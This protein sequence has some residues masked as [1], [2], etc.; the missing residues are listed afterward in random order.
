M[1]S[2]STT[3]RRALVTEA[4]RRIDELTERLA[5]A[6]QGDR[7]PIAVVGIG[8]RL[9]GGV[10]DPEE[11]WDLLDNGI[12]GV[13]RVPGDRWDADELYSPDHTVPGTICNREG[14]FLTDWDPAAFDAEFFGISPREAAGMDPQHR[15]L[16]EV[17]WQAL[18]HAGI[19]PTSLRGSRTGV[20][21]GLTTTDYST[22]LAGALE[23]DEID[24]YV[25]F[26]SAHNFA[27][28]RLSYFLGLNGPAVVL[29][30]ACSSSLSALHLACQGLRSRESD[31]AL[32]AGVNLVLSPENSIACSRWGMLAPD[33]RCKPF[34]ASADGYVR[35]EGCGVVVLK[36]LSDAVA[37]GD[38]VLAV[39][40]G[41]AVNQ[42]G[43]SSGQTVPN[44]PAQQALLR[45]ALEISDLAP[46]TIDFIES[47]GTGTALGD[48]IELDTLARVFGERAGAAP[49]VIGAVK[50]NLGHLESAAGMAGFI[51]T[52]LAL[53]RG[54]I[55]GN[56]HFDA[57]TP[58]AGEG[59]EK[60]VFPTG[61]IDWPALDRP[62]RA[63]VSSFGVSGTNA[64]V[65][66]EQAPPIDTAQDADHLSPDTAAAVARLT[67]SGKSIERIKA[68]A[69][70]LAHWLDGAG[71]S[72]PLADV[73]HELQF[74]RPRFPRIATVIA[75]DHE[76]AV[77][78]LH[79]LAEGRPAPG[80]VAPQRGGRR[81]GTVFVFSGQ[82]AQWAGMGRRLMA[83]DPAFAA[84][85]RELDADFRDVVGFSLEQA[86]SDASPLSGIDR[87]QPVL[88]GVQLALVELWKSRGVEPDA[89]IGHSMG[90]VAAAV[91]AGALSVRDGLTVIATRSA[92][93]KRDLAGR[94]AMALLELDADAAAEVAARHEGVSVA[95]VASPR[96]TV[97][98]GDPDRIDAAI[99]EVSARDLLARRIDVDVASHHATVDPIL[100]ELRASLADI[101]PAVPQIPFHSTV[102][103]GQ[104]GPRVDADYWADN[105]RRPVLFA[106]A[107]S[108]AAKVCGTFI[109]I[110]PHPLLTSAIEDVVDES[111]CVV[112]TLLRDAA[113]AVQFEANLTAVRGPGYPVEPQRPRPPVDLPATQWMRQRHWIVP[114]ASVIDAPA[115][116]AD[117]GPHGWFLELAFPERALAAAEPEPRRWLVVTDED[118]DEL[119]ALLGD[120]AL[121]VRAAALVDDTGAV[122]SALHGVDRVVYAPAMPRDGVDPSSARR[123]VRDVATLIRLLREHGNGARLTVLTRNAEA[124]SEGEVANPAHAALWGAG[125]T[126]ALEHP[127]LWG[128]LID[129]DAALPP[130]LVAAALTAE[131]GAADDEDQV[132]YRTGVRRVPRL[133]R[134]T[135]PIAR[136]DVGGDETHLVIGAT[137]NIGGDV[138]RQL[139]RMGARTV[140]A[141]S[142]RGGLP[143]GLEDELA[144]NGT[145]IVPVAIDAA[146][147]SAMTELFARFG[148]DLPPLGGVYV[149]S[150]AG[151]A[152]L[153]SELSADDI[154]AM[155]RA[156][157]DVLAIV[158]ELSLHTPLRDL[159]VFSSITGLTGSRWLGHYTAANAYADAV[160]AVRRHLGLPVRVVD[161]GLFESWAQAQP[162]TASAGLTPMPND[163]AV[164]CLPYVLGP[165][166]PTRSVIAGADWPL[167]AESFR[168]RAPMKILD[169]LLGARY[170]AAVDLPAP[171][172]GSVQGR[173]D[174]DGGWL[175]GLS[176]GRRP[177]PTPHRVRGVEVV[178]VSVIAATLASVAAGAELRDLRFEYPIVL[179]R[180]RAVHV[181]RSD[182]GI[183]ITSSA[184]PNAAAERWIRHASAGFG[185]ARAGTED[186]RDDAGTRAA[187]FETPEYDA[188][189]VAD[190]VR[191][192]GV[193]GR[194]FPW[195]VTGYVSG[196]GSI[197]AEVTLDADASVASAT[198]AAVH[199]ARLIGRMDAGLLLPVSI[200]AATTGAAPVGDRV[201]VQVT[202]RPG[203]DEDLLVDA[204]IDDADGRT[205][206]E[207]RGLRFAPLE[208]GSMSGA[209]P[210]DLDG[211]D[212]V[213]SLPDLSTLTP[214]QA[215]T[216]VRDLLRAVLARELGTDPEVVDVDSPFPELGLDS[217]MAMAVLRD[218]KAKV[219]VDLSATML[220][221]HPTVAQLAAHIV[222]LVAPALD[223]TDIG[224]T[225]APAETSL[226][227]ELFESAETFSDAERSI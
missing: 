118:G 172:H 218:A 196:P 211:E 128:G 162:D 191:D 145:R 122:R 27:A 197:T 113:E 182:D 63:G 35:S 192:W 154:D 8:C 120:G 121:V 185:T 102:Q 56:L 99:A 18:E 148:D 15:L 106:D 109:E 32:V 48:P 156:K 225:D 42:D 227:D 139:A 184:D 195:E 67:L 55:P 132:L 222:Q 207:L 87:I 158:H 78:G 49:L 17:A 127:E 143:D 90:E 175:A 194:P 29:D 119:G 167:L 44:G 131:A 72:V 193:E 24:P 134:T 144:E 98:A 187:A 4:L 92:L 216:A 9:P 37:A 96:Q 116:V 69:A 217:M 60:F 70:A 53:G 177:Y 209:D 33:G 171:Q 12:D 173:D 101:T 205:W 200:D 88:V 215:Q 64:H 74:R 43:A 189:A 77:R 203:G 117:G 103:A 136:N 39:V 5:I 82:G 224:D 31:A 62:R 58:H 133:R 95:V 212:P 124:V 41:T 163:A 198:D 151:G 6:Q 126:L 10:S 25:P 170:E 174:A 46:D 76:G 164:R 221:D 104:E 181:R 142:R 137:G 40:R 14:G 89:V 190:R 91:T 149:S 147:R 219:G 22:T 130:Q 155:F 110:S 34:D 176:A 7:E 186:D 23:P 107:V 38:R 52:V 160:A 210:A 61:T 202:R 19:V 161:W 169:G 36:R 75:A 54:R 45:R 201:V 223:A 165:E 26:G 13:V 83:D 183:V 112:G 86:L 114:R 188:A 73:A 166:A 59:A 159:V 81:P 65:I 85:V 213:G 20:Y 204:R 199:L 66:V 140:V 84:A 57:L 152:G 50:S 11:Y 135:A 138:I 47:H 71:A 168:T 129:V 68:S 51:K 16:L 80:V 115:P 97:V 79:A 100:D 226:L 180:P 111:T 208:A 30:T 1:T 214:Q 21:V 146:D 150:L 125:R 108:A 179:D 153:L 157:V 123:G 206:C 141:L 3:D 94:G 93:M 2:P 105:L 178:P 220:W 28:G